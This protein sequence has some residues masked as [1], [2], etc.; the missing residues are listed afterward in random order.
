MKTTKLLQTLSESEL[1]KTVTDCHVV[2]QLLLKSQTAFSE[3]I[4]S[5]RVRS[6]STE[7]RKQLITKS[8]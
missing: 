5:T 6:K 3:R 2:I 1:P 7:V 4:V 8:S